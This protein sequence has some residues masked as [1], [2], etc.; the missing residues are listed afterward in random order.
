MLYPLSYEGN[1]HAKGNTT[2]DGQDTPSQ[3]PWAQVGPARVRAAQG[4]MCCP[5]R[6]RWASRIPIQTAGRRQRCGRARV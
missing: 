3:I 2:A 6:W 5:A 4:V 1:C